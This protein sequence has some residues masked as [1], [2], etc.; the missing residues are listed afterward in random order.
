MREYETIVLLKPDVGDQP[1]NDMAQKIKSVVDGE[2][3]KFLAMTT[4]GKKK[5]AYE[6]ANYPKAIFLHASYLGSSGTPKE[7]ERN[8]R[9][10]EDVLRYLTVVLEDAVDPA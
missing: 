10:S 6:I 3:G 9:I 7:L 8:L 4:W 2:S 5:L 1:L